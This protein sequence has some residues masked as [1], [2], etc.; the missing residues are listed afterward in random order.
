MRIYDSSNAPV[1]FCRH[2][3]PTM[4]EAKE[5][6]GNVGDGPDERGNCFDYDSDHPPYSDTEYLCFDCEMPLT[7]KDN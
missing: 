7:D 4:T 5:R 6:F 1:D 3:F 2:C